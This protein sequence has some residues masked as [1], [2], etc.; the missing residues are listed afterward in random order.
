MKY[1]KVTKITDKKLRKAEYSETNFYFCSVFF[2][3]LILFMIPYYFI[4][5]FSVLASL[6][7][8]IVLFSSSTTYD[9][10]SCLLLV[11][12]HAHSRSRYLI[13]DVLSIL[14]NIRFPAWLLWFHYCQFSFYIIVLILFHPSSTLPYLFRDW[15]RM[16]NWKN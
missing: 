12:T 8:Y 1:F 6:Q 16:F 15:F 9:V 10:V 5:F 2:Y 7:F 3:V 11:R 4:R 14:Y 13:S